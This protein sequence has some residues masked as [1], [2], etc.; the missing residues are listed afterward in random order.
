[1]GEK[2]MP[3]PSW[4]AAQKE[5]TAT[6]LLSKTTAFP[7]YVYKTPSSHEM[8]MEQSTPREQLTMLQS[9]KWK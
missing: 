4:I 1:M 5:S 2:S 7:Y 9:S 6:L 3:E 8:L